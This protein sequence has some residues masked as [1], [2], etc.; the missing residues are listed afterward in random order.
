MSKLLPQA[1][2]ISSRIEKI[3]WKWNWN[4]NSYIEERPA[5]KATP[6]QHSPSSVTETSV[7]Q[8]DIHDMNSDTEPENESSDSD[9]EDDDQHP[10][11]A[12]EIHANRVL[13]SRLLTALHGHLDVA[14]ILIPE[15]FN[16]SSIFVASRGV[17]TSKPASSTQNTSSNEATSSQTK[18]SSSQT[19]QPTKGKNS[20]NPAK[21]KHLGDSG[22]DDEESSKQPFRRMKPSSESAPAQFACHWHKY[23]NAKYS[24]SNLQTKRYRNC[25]DPVIPELRR[26][27]YVE[28]NRR[29][30]VVVL[31]ALSG[32]TSG[33]RMLHHSASGA[34]TT[35][36]NQK[37]GNPTKKDGIAKRAT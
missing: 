35:S 10:E 4:R 28:S 25:S 33:L 18:P 34:M 1:L 12:Y 20:S 31:T 30:G 17:H 16:S 37:K 22:G 7:D 6:R 2:T 27:K 15:I 11:T 14:A 32:T 36:T 26:I 9:S 8:F 19:S 24:A 13:E 21:R 23:D 29:A 5:S 3:T